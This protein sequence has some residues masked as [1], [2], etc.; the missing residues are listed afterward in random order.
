[1]VS[2][3]ERAGLR[4]N[5]N[6]DFDRI[7]RELY[8]EIAQRA[9]NCA[10]SQ[11]D[12]QTDERDDINLEALEAHGRLLC[13]RQVRFLYPGDE[14]LAKSTFDGAWHAERSRR[15]A[16]EGIY[17]FDLVAP[18]IA[19]IFEQCAAVRALYA[20]KYPLVI[21]DEFQSLFPTGP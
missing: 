1:M 4:V 3:P 8:V 16:Q 7:A 12:E 21:V 18:A 17:C 2:T 13:G 10:K 15:A 19:T 20:G 5:I 9:Q 6:P 11:E 14:R